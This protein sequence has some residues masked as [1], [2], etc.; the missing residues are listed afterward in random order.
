MK[1]VVIP[2]SKRW[3]FDVGASALRAMSSARRSGRL[4]AFNRRRGIRSTRVAFRRSGLGVTTQHDTKSVYRKKKMPYRKKRRWKRFVKK[5]HGV[6]EKDLGSR[7]VV[8]NLNKLFQNS[9]DGNHIVFGLCLYP[10]K[11]TTNYYSDLNNI[12][13]LENSGDPTAAAG[14]TVDNASKYLFQSAILDLTVRN[15][16]VI[17][18]GASAGFDSALKME[19]DVYEVSFKKF[20]E[21]AVAGY[22]NTI[23]ELLNDNETKTKAI[24][25]AGTEIGY[26]KR[27]VT[28]FELSYTLSRYGMKIWKKTKYQLNNNDTFTYQM[29][30]PKRRVAMQ[31]DLENQGSFNR[32]GWTRGIIVVAKMTPGYTLGIGDG[33]VIERIHVGC[34]RKY[35]YKIEGISE[36]RTSYIAQT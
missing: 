13:A 18:S 27:G 33:Q 22:K 29:R 23:E 5:V 14:V 21:D 24:G 16:S 31:E 26:L 25:G 11:S 4:S 36:D 17:Y 6:A 12:S 20:A 19:V 3:M 15:R 1:R 34:T 35:L 32:P 30:D 2:N 10:Q 28:P 7:Q 8:F 9:T